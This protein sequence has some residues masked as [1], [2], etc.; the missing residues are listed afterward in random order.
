M[1]WGILGIMIEGFGFINLFGNFLPVVVTVG[2]SV[3]I[4]RN[5]LDF[6]V[7]A[8]AADYIAGQSRGPKYSA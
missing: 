5:I 1:R 6:P 7:V 4:L 3:P 2:R 8:Q